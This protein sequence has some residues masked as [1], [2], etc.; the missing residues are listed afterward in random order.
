MRDLQYLMGIWIEWL[1]LKFK[2][3]ARSFWLMCL[4]THTLVTTILVDRA[5]MFVAC[6]LG[7]YNVHTVCRVLWFST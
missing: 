5:H 7:Y 2:A 1:S 6:L 3:S 4:E